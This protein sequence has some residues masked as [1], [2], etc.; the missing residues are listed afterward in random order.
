MG[1]T[2]NLSGAASNI[3]Q[4][5]ANL[6]DFLRKPM[7]QKRLREFLSMSLADKQD[8]ISLAL[9]AAPTI[10]PAKLSVLVKT[11]FEVLSEFEASERAVIF[12]VYCQQIVK[13]PERLQQLN[14]Q[15]LMETFQSLADRQR[16]ILA[17]SFKEVLISF[18]KR[19]QILCLI[20][21]YTK[22]A[23]DLV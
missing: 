13:Q 14:I 6:P 15:K 16:E 18:P 3:I 2:E 5:L 7:L 9:S 21:D 22:Q 17:D 1:G 4:I 23:L 12:E 10:E 11:W 20:P 19:S 8:T